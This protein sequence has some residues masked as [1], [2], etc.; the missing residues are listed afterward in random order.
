[1]KRKLFELLKLKCLISVISIKAIIYKLRVTAIRHWFA[2]KTRNQL[3]LPLPNCLYLLWDY[4]FT[5][6]KSI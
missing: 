2:V 5:Q 1:M 4:G 3:G 6:Y